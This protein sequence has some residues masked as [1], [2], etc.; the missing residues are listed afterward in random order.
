MDERKKKGG[1]VLIKVTTVHYIYKPKA[2]WQRKHFEKE[3]EQIYL[4]KHSSRWLLLILH[5]R[6]CEL[7]SWVSTLEEASGLC[8]VGGSALFWVFVNVWLL[9]TTSWWCGPRYR[10][11]LQGTVSFLPSCCRHCKFTSISHEEEIRESD[12]F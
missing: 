7:L 4:Q 10:L 9:S 11:S 12:C 2:I 1:K 8:R 5:W 6:V 3:S